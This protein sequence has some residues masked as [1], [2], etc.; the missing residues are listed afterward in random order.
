MCCA[1]IVSPSGPLSENE[2]FFLV[3]N[4]SY[5]LTQRSRHRILLRKPLC[6]V[7]SSSSSRL[8]IGVELKWEFLSWMCGT[9]FCAV[10][11]NSSKF[12]PFKLPRTS[13]I[14]LQLKWVAQSIGSCTYRFKWINWIKSL[15]H[16]Y[17]YHCV[18]M[19]VTTKRSC[20][21]NSVTV[22]SKILSNYQF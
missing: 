9:F 1:I 19:D 20:G 16:S 14:I 11:S 8:I 5:C 10:C 13:N 17:V 7:H 18:L 2:L 21:G 4:F 3:S 12:R 22:A 15:I 6:Q